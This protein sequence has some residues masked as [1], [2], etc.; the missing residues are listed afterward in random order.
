M[1]RYLLDTDTAIAAIRRRSGVDFAR[2][3]EHAGT[4]A[5][6]S[7]SVFELQFGAERSA[8]PGRNRHALEE[9]FS[10][11]RVLD[12]DADAGAHAA[13]IRA[14]LASTGTPIGPYDTLIAGAARSRG[15]IVVT[16]NTRGF[17]RVD[18][19]RVV[20]WMRG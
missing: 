16:G 12:F 20:D 14:Q 3:S 4:L 19:L 15:L 7:I 1:L 5:I 6:S 8:D 2:F 13:E 18:G 10:L 9:F 11:L 17:G